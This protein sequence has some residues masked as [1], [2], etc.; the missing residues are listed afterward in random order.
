[1]DE[2]YGF[3]FSHKIF[4]FAKYRN[5]AKRTLIR[6]IWHVSRNRKH[7]KFRI[8]S[9]CETE[10]H[11]KFRFVSLVLRNGRVCKISFGII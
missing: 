10:Q 5:D 6:E 7:A 9:F 8:L 3:H 11:A 2:C 1:M 4:H